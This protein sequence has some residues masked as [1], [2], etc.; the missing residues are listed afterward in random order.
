MIR[1]KRRGLLL[2]VV[3]GSLCATNVHSSSGEPLPDGGLGGVGWG[4]KVVDLVKG[5]QVVELGVVRVRDA[6]WKQNTTMLSA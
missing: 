6:V 5:E 4:N 3:G 1:K 2:T